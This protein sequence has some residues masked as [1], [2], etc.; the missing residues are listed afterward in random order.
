MPS[1]II[2]QLDTLGPDRC[3]EMSY[4]QADA[5]TRQLARSQ[6]EN[7]TVISALLPR[8]L[9]T[10]F[11]HV[12][13]FCRWADDLSDEAGSPEQAAPLL[14]WWRR[15]LDD[16]FAG[17]PRHPVFV[18]LA[19]TL[20]QHDLP[21]QP[22]AD[23]IDAFEQ[24]QRVNRYDTWD[25]L[26]DYCTR[27]ANPVGR[28]ILM[29]ADV[30]DEQS[31][32]LSDQTCTALQLTNFWQDVRR[33]A[34]ERDRVYLPRDLAAQHDLSIQALVQNIKL[35]ARSQASVSCAVCVPGTPAIRAI[36]P[37][38]V[39]AL[40]DAC[41]RTQPLFDQGQALWPRVPSDIRI[42]IELFTRG[43]EAVLRKIRQ[44]GYDTLTQRPRLGSLSKTTL[45]ARAVLGK[46]KR[47]WR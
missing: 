20:Q 14:A 7:F 18:A 10:G 16:C 27:S 15:E 22:F 31:F 47:G 13:A 19:H 24:D 23:L 30:R 1:T 33:D 46:L 29:L 28:L 3:T 6:Y 35:D 8:R 40:R 38:F 43:G 5:Y 12:Y 17:Q 42:D 2:A 34:L 44:Q 37:M 9:R 39:A 32:A 11:R 4:A 36:R 41:D 45:L 25:Q 26:L 21:K